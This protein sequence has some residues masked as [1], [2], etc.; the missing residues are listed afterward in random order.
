MGGV[1]KIEYMT[2][3]IDRIIGLAIQI[4]QIAAPTFHE[5]ERA[6]FVRTLFEEEGLKEI[7]IDEAGNVYGKWEVESGKWRGFLGRLLCEV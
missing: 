6:Q 1:G 5:Q 4:Q 7:S 3:T 2:N